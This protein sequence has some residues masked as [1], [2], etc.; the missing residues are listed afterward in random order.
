MAVEL[1][2]IKA[3]SI[4]SNGSEFDR[5]PVDKLSYQNEAFQTDRN[6]AESSITNDKVHMEIEMSHDSNSECCSRQTLLI[7]SAVYTCLRKNKT[8]IKLVFKSV[9][10]LAYLS[11]VAYAM[12]YRFGG[13]PE[14]RLLIC[15]VF[16][17]MMI[18][19][20]WFSNH[21][22]SNIKNWKRDR[23]A[24]CCSSSSTKRVM[25]H[26][27][28]MLKVAVFIFIVVYVI[29]NIAIDHPENLIAA[30]GVA[31]YIIIF[32]VTSVN[33]AQVDWHPVFWGLALQFIFAL[34]TL[35][36]QWGYDAFKWVGD[37]VT[38]FLVYSDVGAEFVFGTVFAEHLFAF[39]VMPVVVF[40]ATIIS[41]L[42][43][44]GVIPFLIKHAGRFLGFCM[45]TRPAESLSAA[46]NIFLGMTDLPLMLR[47]FLKDLTNSE[48]HAILTG[49][50]A[51]IA[52]SVL[53]AYISFGVPAN[54][55]L[56]ASVMSAPAAL[57]LSKLSYPELD[58]SKTSTTDYSKIAKSA[59]RNIFDA[60][61]H[62]AIVSAKLV[63]AIIV[64][65]IAFLSLLEFVNVTLTWFGE[66]VGVEDFTLEF[67]C[68]Y[69]FYPIAYFM[70][71]D[72]PD[73]R[74]VATLVAKKTFTNEYI[75]YFDLAKIINNRKEL[76]KFIAT[77][78]S[79]SLNWWWNNNDVIY[80]N[81]TQNITLELG[82][83]SDKSEVVATYALCGFANFG[84][85]G[86]LLGALSALVPSREGDI[87]G[88]ILRAM[89][90]GN[91][92]CFLTGSI[93]GLLYKG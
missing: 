51:T 10:L 31:L 66:R 25:F 27:K 26:L 68:S 56:T 21:F 18:I 87:T 92:A 49:G 53:G 64:N 43:Y 80:N 69:L 33:P 32:Y 4:N 52:G 71:A 40:M 29:I 93:A 48:L 41:I 86:I 82:I 12:Y 36:T 76:T 88:M 37:R 72:V 2:S 20:F 85:M 47:P 55:L 7:Q 3:S 90:T 24:P 59:D 78:N 8:I 65:V 16:G 60:A 63:A 89:I 42:Y 11:Y 81:G 28:W 83:M 73:C 14:W 17:L 34:I 5:I 54:H 44:L 39:K 45:G 79:S 6:D 77:D 30:A 15:S 75:A 22:K 13:E 19:G 58:R 50:F 57:A 70:G 9:L 67:I 38:E 35:E 1:K 84:S 46:G 74:Q 61:T 23:L 62:G 91:A